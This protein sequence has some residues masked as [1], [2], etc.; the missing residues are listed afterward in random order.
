MTNEEI[1]KGLKA[2][3][4]ECGEHFNESGAW[5]QEFFRQAI[6]AL[7]QEPC[8]DAI[9]RQEVLNILDDMVREYI[10]E[11]D[12]DKAQGVAWVKVQR[13]PSVS[14]EKTGRWIKIKPYP[15]QMHDYEC[16]ECG[17]E[18][19][20]STEKYCSECGCRMTGVEE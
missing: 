8:T 18:T 14:T 15:L 16:S 12:F 3:Y 4:K 2:I 10:K 5:M 9:S 17:H 7:S 20:D 13:L 11:N 19:D 6:K 1:T